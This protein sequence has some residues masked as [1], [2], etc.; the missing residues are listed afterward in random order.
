MK[1]RTSC[2]HPSPPLFLAEKPSRPGYNLRLPTRVQFTEHANLD[3]RDRHIYFT[4][5]GNEMP[6]RMGILSDESTEY[7]AILKLY[8]ASA[9]QLHLATGK[10]PVF[11]MLT[12]LA[13]LGVQAIIDEERITGTLQHNEFKH[14]LLREVTSEN[15]HSLFELN[16]LVRDS[17]EV[18][19]SQLRVRLELLGD[20]L[21]D[22]TDLHKQEEQA[23]SCLEVP[24]RAEMEA[25][26][27]SPLGF[28][29]RHIAETLWLITAAWL[30]CVAQHLELECE[31]ELQR[32]RVL[33]T[34]ASDELQERR[35]NER[36]W[37]DWKEGVEELQASGKE[38]DLLALEEQNGACKVWRSSKDEYFAIQEEESRQRRLLESSAASNIPHG[39]GPSAPRTL[40]HVEDE[41]VYEE[42][43]A[44]QQQLLRQH[45]VEVVDLY[46]LLVKQEANREQLSIASLAW[47]QGS[48]TVTAARATLILFQL[49]EARRA[50]IHC[51]ALVITNC[52]L[53][54]TRRGRSIL[55][56]WLQSS[57]CALAQRH[58]I[59]EET[60]ERARR[61]AEEQMHRLRFLAP[62]GEMVSRVTLCAAQ[63][64]TEES[65]R[66]SLLSIEAQ[67]ERERLILCDELD[68]AALVCEVFLRWRVEDISVLLDAV[69]E[70]GVPWAELHVLCV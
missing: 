22:K 19:E 62:H 15:I 61:Q 18:A 4:V 68:R 69:G 66:R 55:Q 65:F 34:A 14:L 2:L 16:D 27:L 47:L 36:E 30:N 50:A 63:L 48:P 44:V 26:V 46:H 53:V 42:R 8:A 23:R 41:I 12:Q 1:K 3:A 40:R 5:V 10:G 13:F 67:E 31:V 9:N 51:H 24:I 60:R 56:E 59:E 28:R 17:T 57:P 32:L 45:S 11:S 49:E 64:G 43:F 52:I 58:F 38:N 6:E 35:T 37:L 54:A 39:G 70:L 7:R 29:L 20:Y 25:F 33:F 21:R